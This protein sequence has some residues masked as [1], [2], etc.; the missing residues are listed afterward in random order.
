VERPN[1]EFGLD[2]LRVDAREVE[3]GFG[4][5]T[6]EFRAVVLVRGTGL[7]APARRT[8]AFRYHELV[9]L[10]L[11]LLVTQPL[12][13]LRSAAPCRLRPF[14]LRAGARAQTAHAV[15]ADLRALVGAHAGS[16]YVLAFLHTSRL[17]L[18]PAHRPALI[19]GW[20]RLQ[21]QHHAGVLDRQPWRL[22][23]PGGSLTQPSCLGGP[24][25]S[26]TQPS[27]LGGP[28]GSLTQPSCLGGPGGFLTQPSCLGGPGGFLTQPSCLGGPGGFLTPSCLF[29]AYR[30]GLGVLG[31]YALL[32][33]LGLT[34]ELLV[35]PPDSVGAKVA[36]A[37]GCAAAVALPLV[38]CDRLV[39]R[40]KRRR[41]GWLSALAAALFVGLAVGLRVQWGHTF[42]A[43]HATTATARGE[44]V[45]GE[46]RAGP[47][48]LSASAVL[49][50]LEAFL[51]W[52]ALFVTPTYV[53]YWCAL[54]ARGRAGA[55]T[56][57]E[58]ADRWYGG[59][60]RRALRAPRRAAPRRDAR[61]GSCAHALAASA[62]APS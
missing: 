27:C 4:S 1:I 44:A 25:G 7:G 8:V 14:P 10:H 36:L 5:A 60:A 24:G 56:R 28:G 39:L 52:S 3:H 49:L 26:L 48:R 47:P 51:L 34:L 11:Q 9:H 22:G 20:A 21:C 50:T 58:D 37:V 31:F 15:L 38:F 30:A 13:Y 40:P 2:V 42:R 45:D 41:R 29:Q 57:G 54:R 62:P 46:A 17:V 6:C 59:R 43:A 55:H 33:L 61:L 12:A 18:S 53:L 23:G 16:Q 32:G 35:G 19:A